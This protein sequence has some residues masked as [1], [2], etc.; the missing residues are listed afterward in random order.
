MVTD[1]NIVKE[2]DSIPT[3]F[4]AIKTCANDGES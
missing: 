3:G 1:I 4:T 2:K